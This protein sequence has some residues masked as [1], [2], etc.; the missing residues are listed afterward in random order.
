MRS[1]VA[2]VPPPDHPIASYRSREKESRARSEN[3]HGGNEHEAPQWA[4]GEAASD[5]QRGSGEQ[6]NGRN[7][8]G[9]REEQPTRPTLTPNPLDNGHQP[10][11]H[12]EKCEYQD[13]SGDAHHRGEQLE[14]TPTVCR[15]MRISSAQCAVD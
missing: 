3:A 2:A 8:I 1:M 9:D 14:P 12:R 13:E 11:R 4:V 15:G 10:R 7:H 5:G 6:H